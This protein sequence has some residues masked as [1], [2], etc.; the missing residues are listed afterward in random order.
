MIDQA[1]PERRLWAAVLSFAIKDAMRKTPSRIDQTEARAALD[2]HRDREYVKTASFDE[3]CLLAGVDP[4]Y[5]RDK[6]KRKMADENQK[7]CVGSPA[8]AGV[9]F[10]RVQ[11]MVMK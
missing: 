10:Q 6:L 3:V 4:Q 9:G 7:L 11:A 1:I 2:W 5:A 8:E